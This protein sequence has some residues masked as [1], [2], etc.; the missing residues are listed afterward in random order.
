MKTTQRDI[1]NPKGTPNPQL[2][3]SQIRQVVGYLMSIRKAR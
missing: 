3:D 1:D 2:L